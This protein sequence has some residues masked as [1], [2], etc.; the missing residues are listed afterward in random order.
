VGLRILAPSG[1]RAT[2]GDNAGAQKDFGVAESSLQEVTK[3][4]NNDKVATY[5]HNL[6][7][8]VVKQHAALLDG[9]SKH[10]EAKHLL[11]TFE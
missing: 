11:A 4:I 7:G 2:V 6:L 5:Y 10:D 9:E 8:S 3:A 1:C